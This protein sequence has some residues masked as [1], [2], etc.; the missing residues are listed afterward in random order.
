MDR[1]HHARAISRGRSIEV[2]PK[3]LGFERLE[4]RLVLSA[5][6]LANYDTVS[7]EWFVAPSSP[8]T[9]T[10]AEQW[11]I[12]LTPEATAQA[13]TVDGAAS[14]LS[15]LPMTVVRGLG[16]PG[17]LLV[18]GAGSTASAVNEALAASPL[19][20]TFQF[21]TEI[22][23]SQLSNDPDLNSGL[24]TTALSQY[25]LYNIGQSQGAADADIDAD[26]AWDINTG[27]SNVVVAVIDSGVYYTHPDLAANVWTNTAETPGDGIDNDGN[28][29]IDDVRGWDFEN[30]DNNPVDDHGH[31]THVAGAIGAVGNNSL[32]VTGVNWN[33]SILPVKFLDENNVGSVAKAIEA[34]NYVTM[35]RTHNEV[36]VRVINASWGGA[37]ADSPALRAAIAAA[38]DAGILF[39]SAAGNG[40]VFG[41]GQNI[42]EFPFYPAS[43]S[44]NNMLVVAATDR[45]D[46]LATFSNY[47]VNSVDIAAP[48]LSVWN[49]DLFIDGATTIANYGVR[50]GTSMATPLVAGVAALAWSWAPTASL[51]EVRD[52]ILAGGDSL[53]TLQGKVASGKRLNAYGSLLSLPPQA[54]TTSA[55]DVTAIGGTSYQ[56]TVSLKS[57]VGITPASVGHGDFIVRRKG[58][59]GSDLTAS[60]VSSS[61]SNANK[62]WTATYQIT[63]PAGTWDVLDGGVYEIVL[64]G[65]SLVDVNGVGSHQKTIDEFAVNLEN[66]GVY[67]PTVFTDG[68]PGSLREAIALA[69][70]VTP[71]I[72]PAGGTVI[73]APGTYTLSLAGAGEDANATGDL[74][75]TG[76]VTLASDGTGEVIINAQG[77]DRVFDV[78]ASGNLTIQGITVTGGYAVAEDGGGIR[79]AGEL[80]VTNSVVERNAT[81]LNG[82]GIFNAAG[83][84]ANIVA[85]TIRD[86]AAQGSSTPVLQLSGTPTRVNTTTAGGQYAPSI[87]VNASGEAVIAW[88]HNPTGVVDLYANSIDVYAQRLNPEGTLS[89][90]QFQADASG[91]G[92]FSRNP[93]V[94]LQNDGDIG[95]AY[96]VDYGAVEYENPVFTSFDE[97]GYIGGILTASQHGSQFRTQITETADGNYL[98]VWSDTYGYDGSGY[99]TFARTVNRAATTLGPVLT[100][101]DLDKTSGDQLPTGIARMP[102]GEI[103]VVFHDLSGRDG[104]ASGA[105]GRMLDPA[106]TPIGSQFQI[107][108]TTA[109]EQWYPRVSASSAGFVVTWSGDSGLKMRLY[110]ASGVAVSDEISVANTT[111]EQ[112]ATV[113]S[114]RLSDGSIVVV[115]DEYAGNSA[116]ASVGSP[117]NDVW[118]QQFDATGVAISTPQL[119]TSTARF[120]FQG[121]RIAADN[122]GNATIVWDGSGPGDSD[123]IFLQRISLVDQP[124]GGEGGGI[125]NAGTLQVSQSTIGGNDS[126]L[127]GGGVYN[128]GTLTATNVTI[129]GNEAA[130]QGG[131]LFNTDGA[132][133]TLSSVTVTANTALG[134]GGELVRS[135]GEVFRLNSDPSGVQWIPKVSFSPTGEHVVA[136]TTGSGPYTGVS[137]QGQLYGA[138]NSPVGGNVAISNVPDSSRGD[139]AMQPGGGFVS[140]YQS[141]HADGS[142]TGIV[143]RNFN[144][145]GQSITGEYTVNTSA[146]GAQAQ[147]QVASD[148]LGNYTVVWYSDDGGDGSGSRVLMRRFSPTGVP[149]MSQATVNTTTSGNQG[150]PEI[151]VWSNGDFVIVYTSTDPLDS[152]YGIL[153][154]RFDSSGE[155]VGSEFRVNTTTSGEQNLPTVAA[156]PN[157]FLVV[158][159]TYNV[160][161]FGQLYDRQGV[162]IGGEFPIVV[163]SSGGYV[164]PRVVA[165]PD[166]NYAI[167][168]ELDPNHNGIDFD[169]FI[170]VISASGQFLTSRKVLSSTAFQLGLSS[171]SDIG[172]DAKGNILVVWDGLGP[173]DSQGIYGQRL[174]LIS[175][176][177]GIA[178]AGAV[179]L[180]NSLIAKNASAHTSPDVIGAFNSLGGNLIGTIGTASG[181]VNGSNGNKVGTTAAPLDP[182]LGPL[183]DNGGP[184]KTH[185]PAADSP[186]IDAG[187]AG[188]P[189]KDQRGVDRPKDGDNNGTPAV[190]IG[191]VERYYASIS[192]RKFKD[193]N[194]NGVQDAGEPGLAGWTMYL[195]LNQNGQLDAGE[196]STVTDAQGNYAFKQLIPG[197]YTVAE[198]NQTGWTRTFTSTVYASNVEQGIAG[199]TGITAVHELALSPDGKHA[200]AI[201][202]DPSGADKITTF[203][204]DATTGVL[205]FVAELATAGLEGEGHVVV[206]PDGAFVYALGTADNALVIFSRNM[207]TGALTFVTKF[208]NTN[209]GVNAMTAPHDLAAAIATNGN[210]NVY[211]AA[212]SRV[213]LFSRSATTGIWSS[214]LSRAEPGT[215]IA[216][217]SDGGHIYWTS[218]GNLVTYGRTPTSGVFSTSTPASNFSNGQTASGGGVAEGLTGVVDLAFS[219][220]G[221]YLYTLSQTDHSIGVYKRTL[222]TGALQFIEKIAD[223]AADHLGT[224]VDGLD[225]G[226]SLVV[227]PGGDRVYLTSDADGIEDDI[228]AIFQRNPATGRLHFLHTL[229]QTGDDQLGNSILSMSDPDGVVVSPDGK[230]IYVAARDGFITGGAITQFARD[231]QGLDRKTLLVGQELTDVNFSSYAAPGEIRG[232]I[233]SDVDN[234]G[235][236]DAEEVGLGGI[237]LYLDADN[238]NAYDDGEDYV[239]TD[240]LGQYSFQNLVTPANYTVRLNLT[241]NQTV[242]SPSAGAERE[243]NLTPLNPNQIYV[244]ADFLVYV[245][246]TGVGVGTGQITGLVWQ[247]IDGDGI[248]QANEP[249]LIGRRVYLDVNDNG[250]YDTG[251]DLSTFSSAGGIYTFNN[252]GAAN[253][254]IRVEAESDELTTTTKGNRFLKETLT[255]GANPLG[256]VTAD[257][258]N[259]E[260]PDLASVDGSTD[261]VSVRLQLAN[262]TFD[263][264]A[265]YSVD[266]YPTGIT[267]GKFNND[268][269]PDIAVVHSAHPNK[270]IFLINQGD[271]TFERAAA[272]TEITLSSGYTNLVAADIDLDG[273]DDLAVTVD[274]SADSVHILKNNNGV[275]PSFTPLQQL[276]LGTAAPLSI[277]AGDL[278]GDGRPE[279]VVGNFV[280]DNVR[281]LLNAGGTS[282]TLQTPI[283]VADGPSSVAIVPDMN[284]DGHKDLV[285]ASSGANAV[286]ILNGNGA[287]GFSSPTVIPVGQGPRT[288]AVADVD[289]DNDL[290]L[291]VG[292]SLTNDVVVLRRQGPGL[293]FSFAESSGLANFSRLVVSGVKHVLATDLDN[294]GV[295]DLAAVRGDIN[296]GSLAVL[297]NALAPGSIR[298]THAGSGT[299]SNQNFGIVSTAVSNPGDFDNDGDVDGRDFLIWQRGGSPSPLSSGNLSD[300][301]N[302]Y[303]ETAPVVALNSSIA[304][305]DKS[306][307]LQDAPVESMWF[308]PDEQFEIASEN[309]VIEDQAIPEIDRALEE[310]D[311]ITYTSVRD[312]GDIAVRRRPAKRL[313]LVCELQIT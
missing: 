213:Y 196:R 238:D 280:G 33:T 192:G 65:G 66:I 267:V 11:I 35:L 284:G 10:S 187:I 18:S 80:A 290:D 247:D 67:R 254:V 105:F 220:D 61:S 275:A 223:G 87:S 119:I 190:D 149:L 273:D 25:A 34:V 123:G 195:D 92:V 117:I 152:D 188:A 186:A 278:N 49:T 244:G 160:G 77:I 135:A 268:S 176:G 19:L 231:S 56:F 64:V 185:L 127:N 59:T 124:L 260:L 285:I 203:S 236:R 222:A 90:A 40:D 230:F 140:V 139:V 221:L 54:A 52:A 16:L 218:G 208:D 199:V 108:T 6:S 5:N 235:V 281:V 84:I 310:L 29:K 259:D 289:D 126:A 42:D 107:N 134:G 161:A 180:L 212:N 292:N 113:N 272:A 198:V 45:N 31:G 274:G 282:F 171:W 296:G 276:S 9:S 17:Q 122:Q 71:A 263:T 73:L 85:S 103:M 183:A 167:S 22:S 158:W 146:S 159:D 47:G 194:Q 277:A 211:V 165:L 69:N 70:A 94:V 232:T 96:E 8:A 170:Q 91:A 191:A 301:R 12:R 21:D 249:L 184:T 121:P 100:I 240:S 300:W 256:L 60:L 168:G 41:R 137:F 237:T 154:Q 111:R 279:L 88:N 99:G 97:N 304:A 283:S 250:V 224:M 46:Q 156:G 173:D 205:T 252:L 129:S 109:G 142:S 226:K 234:D 138:G 164:A 104:S 200:Y 197:F 53:S 269:L 253:F 193:Q 243:Y 116:S 55:I 299:V 83:K 26:L 174:E 216:V 257:F 308:L 265:E 182:K 215:A 89:G 15:N 225:A 120:V 313:A 148:S 101:P 68:G 62:Q 13:R 57:N 72:N 166:G 298:L 7:P 201:N 133:G 294:N 112:S 95:F 255:T 295:M 20:A 102:S 228:L 98:I 264:R 51:S 132:T 79:N 76:K 74:D 162:P 258:N 163:G 150:A 136:W 106:G 145:S 261:K 130:N 311:T 178:N 306:T 3:R 81:T 302:H 128:A 157:G 271:G 48:G 86:N 30:N 147:T 118:M 75:I 82:A 309:R 37:G 63:P 179:N 36:N 1:R 28:G 293:N 241:Q 23:G 305:D 114:A 204:R 189:V 155:K 169:V 43:Y 266:S 307:A 214:L 229:R 233:Y 177:G 4:E 78:K 153:G 239:Q 297:H 286:T 115:W 27:S 144:S 131:G 245:Q 207:M 44:L 143:A 39:V 251:V 14:L 32:G 175:D 242:T 248:R 24:H 210:Q 151:D 58:T 38:G 141:P 270:V 110:D 50:S 246:L 303:G 93:A 312:L 262:G 227:S 2:L 125:Y 287:A 202:S 181:I 219:S 217:P 206:S 288:V 172:V 209:T 291:I